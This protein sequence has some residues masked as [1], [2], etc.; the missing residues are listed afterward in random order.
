MNM[1][2]GLAFLT[3]AVASPTYEFNNVHEY[4]TDEEFK[5]VFQTERPNGMNICWC[6]YLSRYRSF[7]LKKL[8]FS[9]P[10]PEYNVTQMSHPNLHERSG[11]S[12][13]R[14]HL[15]VFGCDIDLSLNPTDGILAGL[16]TPVYLASDSPDSYVFDTVD[17]VSF[18][19]RL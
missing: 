18:Q 2:F 15:N 16:D 8:Y 6:A 19:I 3:L 11:D 7:L 9:F 4:M 14:L 13:T 5:N 17:D 12:I 1:I 10:V